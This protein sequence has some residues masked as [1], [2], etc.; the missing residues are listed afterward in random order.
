MQSNVIWA[1]IRHSLTSETSVPDPRSDG[2]TCLRNIVKEELVQFQSKLWIIES[3][4]AQ[5][6]KPE[7]PRGTAKSLKPHSH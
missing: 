2:T 5:L 3:S 6:W 7:N 4:T 1:K